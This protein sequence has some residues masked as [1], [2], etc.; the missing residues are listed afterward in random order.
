MLLWAICFNFVQDLVAEA[1]VKICFVI[2][3]KL[4]GLGAVPG[5]V[6]QV[7]GCAILWN[8]FACFVVVDLIGL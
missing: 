8:I 2:F 5:L 4:D 3:W 7:S 6:G 1:T